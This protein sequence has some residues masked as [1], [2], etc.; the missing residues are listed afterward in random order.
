M[1]PPVSRARGS[2]N[3]PLLAIKLGPFSTPREKMKAAHSPATVKANHI[4]GKKRAR[5][6]DLILKEEGADSLKVISPSTSSRKGSPPGVSW[7]VLSAAKGASAP[8][9][10]P[11]VAALGSVDRQAGPSVQQGGI[12]D[13]KTATQGGGP[14]KSYSC[15]SCPGKLY[16]SKQT[17]H[18]HMKNFHGKLRNTFRCNK[19]PHL[20]YSSKQT[21]KVHMKN[22]HGETLP[23][24]PED[25]MPPAK[26]AK[27]AKATTTTPP[28]PSPPKGGLAI[29]L[30]A[31][32]IFNNP[33]N[34][35]S[36]GEKN[37]IGKKWCALCAPGKWISHKNFARHMRKHTGYG[38]S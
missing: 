25:P 11:T 26:K 17:L 14:E 28:P 13:D 18:V 12:D 34:K 1:S 21:L 15:P 20:V 9:R 4:V 29:L 27:K 10:S 38:T 33:G 24:T 35:F 2:S 16:A 32:D 22:R 5:D 19:C 36:H 23:M 8:S 7:D 3:G 6:E 30:L 37:C 31:T